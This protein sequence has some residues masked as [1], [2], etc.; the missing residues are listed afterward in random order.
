MDSISKALN[1]ASR[2]RRPFRSRQGGEQERRIEYTHT[3]VVPV[4]PQL[5]HEKRVITQETD[6]IVVDAYKLLRT[7]VMSRM[8]TNDW[9][10]LGVTSASENEGK[11]LTS[12]NLAISI[13]MKLNYTVV[14][15]DADMRRPSVHQLFGIE[16]ELGL[17]DHLE[18]GA[19]LEN[20]LINPG[21]DR[22]V[23]LPGRKSTVGSSELLASPRMVQLVQELKTRYPSRIVVFDLP[24]ALLGD[25]VAA[26]SPHMDAAL[27]VV[28]DGQTQSEMLSKSVELLEGVNLLG[29]VLNKS[30]EGARNEY[31]Y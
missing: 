27:L 11:T 15:I 18:S 23:L 21:I 12:T 6:P 3:Q 1:I 28:E 26:F 2:T 22:L 17:S 16:P 19:P 20:I 14:L 9:K 31:Y 4:S 30:M 24:P 25:D 29:T 7:R 13:A 10:A 8:Q 5:L